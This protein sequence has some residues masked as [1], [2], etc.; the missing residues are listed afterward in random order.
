MT[1]RL[2][3]TLTATDGDEMDDDA[4]APIEAG[5]D[6]VEPATR[7]VPPARMPCPA[8]GSP[9]TQ[10]FTHAGPAARVNMRCLTCGHQFRDPALRR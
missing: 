3:P 8:C 10:P 2:S 1:S 7:P 9:R 4:A 6:D 5:A